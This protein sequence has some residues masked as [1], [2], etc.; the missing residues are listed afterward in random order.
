MRRR[1]IPSLAAALTWGM[2]LLASPGTGAEEVLV[3]K[4]SVWSYLDDGSDQGTVWRESDFVE[5]WPTGPAELGFGDGQAG[6][7]GTVLEDVGMTCYFRH[8]FELDDDRFRRI[9]ALR[10][11]VRRDDGAIVYL[12]GHEIYRLGVDPGPTGFDDDGSTTYSESHFYRWYLSAEH[13][14]AGTNVVAVEMHKANLR[15]DDLSFDL[16]L[17]GTTGEVEIW[18]GP[19]L[20][21]GTPHGATIRFSTN[22]P[23]TP[24]LRYG[25]SLSAFAEERT[26]VRGTDHT[27][28]LDGLV[29][30][31]RYFYAVEVAGQVLVGGDEDH[32]F[33]THPEP[34]TRRPARIW[35]I[36]DSGDGL[37]SKADP[38]L[39]SYLALTGS[40]ET[41]VWLLLGDNAYKNGTLME[42]QDGL[43]DAFSPL[44]RNTF[45]WPIIGNHDKRAFVGNYH[46]RGFVGAT[47]PYFDVFALPA[48]GESGGVASGTEYYYSF[49]YGNIHFV[50]LYGSKEGLASTSPQLDWLERDLRASDAEWTIVFVHISP[51]STGE[52]DSDLIERH[53]NVRE[54]ALPILEEHEVDLV[55]SGH[56][57]CYQRSY[58]IRH[59]YGPSRSWDPA[60]HLVDGGDGC[61]DDDRVSDCCGAGDGAYT[62]DGTVYAVVG[63][64]SRP[65]EP[66]PLTHPVMACGLLG[67]E[68]SLVID[69]EGDTLEARALLGDGTVAD[70]FVIGH[71][72]AEPVATLWGRSGWLV[73]GLLGLLGLAV[74]VVWFVARRSRRGPGRS[75]GPN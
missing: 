56:S 73:P 68:G 51:Y 7:E 60:A 44:L 13:L 47:G 42:Y 20:Q 72:S 18:R 41:D 52:H 50:A 14:R 70:R 22:V 28:V 27:F 54:N 63:N 24:I 33:R 17:V 40:R 45:A 5:S 19:Y 57:H 64:S 59:H 49:D 65:T 39:A 74:V 1:R 66:G 11:G 38:V 62:G 26:G 2:L 69:V 15:D 32:R 12:N 58:L 21:R 30:D 48:E 34:G 35:V 6:A 16:E 71:A 23:V 8:A 75:Q 10:L 43:F 3:P 55:L 31:T 9:Q 29:P 37:F 4:Q 46:E 61:P 36:G 25:R 53:V 67:E